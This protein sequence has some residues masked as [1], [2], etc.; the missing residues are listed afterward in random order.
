MRLTQGVLLLCALLTAP[1]SPRAGDNAA[2]S[3]VLRLRVVTDAGDVDGTGFLIH[4]DDR[5]PDV[6]LYFL[7]SARLFR[8]PQGGPSP[9]IQAARVFLGGEHTLD[10]PRDDIFVCT[11]VIDVAVVRATSPSTTLVPRPLVYDPPSPGEVFHISGYGRDGARATVAE[12]VRFLSTLL[13]VG[14]R[15]A[16][17]LVGCVGAPAI[18][19][20]GA[21]GLVSECTAGRTP[22]IA[23]F[24]VARAFI[25]RHVPTN[26]PSTPAQA[27]FPDREMSRPAAPHGTDSADGLRIRI[28]N[29]SALLID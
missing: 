28:S 26:R 12:R 27:S 1:A 10:V 8:D 17:A 6:A 11:G 22:T 25:E 21:F 7:T 2:D 9:R 19:R 23:L 20:N 3:S 14:D 13:A 16:S 4:R 18:S 15:D 29:R 5:N 24:S